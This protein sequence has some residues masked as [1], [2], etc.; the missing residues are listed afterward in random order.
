ML[1]RT[2]NQYFKPSRFINLPQPKPLMAGT[3]SGIGRYLL[4]TTPDATAAAQ[5]ITSGEHSRRFFW[6]LATQSE[7]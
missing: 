1:E 2:N 6:F 5:A 3:G 4:Q 7:M